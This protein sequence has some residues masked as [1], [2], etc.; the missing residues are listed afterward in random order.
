MSIYV[1]LT[2][3]IWLILSGAAQLIM[4]KGTRTH[5]TIGWTWMLA[6]I[7][8]SVSSFWITGVVD[9]FLGYGPIHLL[10]IWVLVCVAVSL[11]A[12]RNGNIRFTQSLYYRGLRR[13]YRG[14]DCC[15]AGAESPA[16]QF[17]LSLVS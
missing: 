2:A 5:K 10:S 14:G 15:F 17:F 7:V 3:A 11:V 8:V 16:V 1:H 4:K 6:M 13:I 9:W 12:I